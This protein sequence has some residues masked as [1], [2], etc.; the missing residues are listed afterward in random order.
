MISGELGHR[1]EAYVAEL[2]KS[3]RYR[4]LSEVLR[5]GVRLV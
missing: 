5:E 4:S 3:G 1:L 2:V